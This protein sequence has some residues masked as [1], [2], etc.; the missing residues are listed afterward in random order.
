ML[1]LK[2]DRALPKSRHVSAKMKYLDALIDVNLAVNKDLFNAKNGGSKPAKS[3]CHSA[4]K[5]CHIELG[6]AERKQKNFRIKSRTP[7]DHSST[8]GSKPLGI[9]FDKY[10][11]FN[12]YNIKHLQD[13]ERAE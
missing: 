6:G 13:N 5:N 12:L 4:N 3:T 9:S 10:L 7:M 8:R 11:L 2:G 1:P